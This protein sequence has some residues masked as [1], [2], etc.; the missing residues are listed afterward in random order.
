AG[1]ELRREGDDVARPRALVRDDGERVARGETDGPVGVAAPEAGALDEPGGGE[2]HAPV[3]LDPARHGR[4]ARQGLDACAVGGTDDRVREEGPT[5]PA[6][7]VAWIE[8][9]GFRAADGEHGLAHVRER[10]D[11]DPAGRQVLLDVG[12]AHGG[13]PA[14]PRSTLART[15]SS[16][17]S[18]AAA[19]SSTAPF[20]SRDATPRSA[21]RA[22]TAATPSSA[23]T[24]FEPPPR[25]RKGS[26]R[27]RA[28]ARAS[29]SPASS[30]TSL[31]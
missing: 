29:R 13:R 11:G 7:R 14:G 24:R 12:V 20:T 10:R 2:L 23:T 25:T 6:V 4:V 5:A 26:P 30:R 9:H 19:V 31:K 15:R 27:R 8:H 18:P 17:G 3:G 28:H 22:T 1:L 16:Q 21:I